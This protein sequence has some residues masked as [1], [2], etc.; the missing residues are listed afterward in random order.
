M[1]YSTVA[2][3]GGYIAYVSCYIYIYSMLQNNQV[4][5]YVC[6]CSLIKEAPPLTPLSRGV[7]VLRFFNTSTQQ[8]FKEIRYLLRLNGLNSGLNKKNAN[9]LLNI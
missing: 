1:L 7:S 3:D 8:L 4:M 2:S 5:W 6:V 9:A